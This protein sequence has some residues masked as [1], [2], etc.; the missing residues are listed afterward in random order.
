[1]VTKI[2]FLKTWGTYA[3]GDIGETDKAGAKTLVEQGIAEQY[4]EV[5]ER[6]AAELKEAERQEIVKLAVDAMKGVLN[7]PAHKASPIVQHI[8][9]RDDPTSNFKSMGDFALTVKAW[10]L[11]DQ[12]DK[13]MGA[14]M[15]KAAETG[16][17][18]SIDSDGGFLV[19]EE[20]SNEILQ[21]ARDAA[22]IVARCRE[23]PM[24]TKAL[25]IP[26]VKETS[27]ADGSRQGGIRAY[28]ANELGGLTA[29]HPTFGGIRLEVNK[30]Y[31][32][33]PAS[34][35]L[36]EDAAAM[37][38]LISSMAGTELG[39]VMDDCVLNGTGAGQPLGVLHSPC[40]ISVAKETGQAADT[41][42][43]ENISK[44]WSRMYG[45]CRPNAVWLINQD[46]EPQLDQL[47]IAVGTGGSAVYMPAGGLSQSPFGTLK[48][49]PVIPCE[50]CDTLGDNGDI[51]LADFSQYLWGRHVSGINA[52]T[53][54]H[55]K[56]DYD[57]TIFRFIVRVDG[58]PWWPGTLTPKYSA[59]TLS[60]FVA[61]AARA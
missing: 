9:D 61:L 24:N 34:E 4:D 14:W 59:D 15:R 12:S 2:K 17:N 26:Y 7:E 41:V 47:S 49:R 54:I 37:G 27:R 28:W 42:V 55:V 45:P 33:V 36:L 40:L 13:R 21:K 25:K 60:P 44:M 35:E 5:A 1:M 39:D 52:A 23:V 22:S 6:K 43:A 8:N 32:Y 51:V 46:V 31:C 50:W 11:G 3:P 29:S 18:E 53:S 58:Q 30:L 38:S 20:F 57:Q 56:F 16:L 48:G 10:T 19:P